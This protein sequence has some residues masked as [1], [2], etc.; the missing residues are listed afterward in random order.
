MLKKISVSLL[1]ASLLLNAQEVPA[2]KEVKTPQSIINKSLEQLKNNGVVVENRKTT[3]TNDSFDMVVKDLSKALPKDANITTKDVSGFSGIKAHSD[4]NY[5]KDGYTAISYLSGLPNNPDASQEEKITIAQ[6]LKERLIYITTK[7]SIKDYKYNMIF[8][9][10][11]TILAKVKVKISNFVANGTYNPDDLYSQN[12]KVSIGDIAIK[13]LEKRYVGEYLN[14]K[15]LYLSTSLSAKNNLVDITYTTGV[16]SID[17]NLSKESIN[18]NKLNS[19]I[20]LGNINKEAYDKIIKLAQSKVIDPQSPEFLDTV[21]KLITKGF[22]IEIK[23]LSLDSA[24]IK[25]E[26]LGLFKLY[27]KASLKPDDKLAQIIKISPMMALGALSVES[28]ITIS[29]SLF[30]LIS[31]FPQGAMLAFIPPKIEKGN[32][33]YNISFNDGKLLVNG[34]P[35]Q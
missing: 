33:V 6:I 2:K 1:M 21:S 5:T 27:I 31:K 19:S 28:K 20:K 30:E 22:Y 3:A 13:P 9:D 12:G 26:K 18:I 35:M 32:M 23:D 15:N 25:G 14:I 34:K 17:G 8:K 4:I 24:L 16:D 10:I 7:Y 29:K 11:D